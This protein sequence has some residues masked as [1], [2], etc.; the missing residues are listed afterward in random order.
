M[1][2]CVIT[3]FSVLQPF[4]CEQRV[5]KSIESL[6]SVRL[7]ADQ[8]ARREDHLSGESAVW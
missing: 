8:P 1:H 5:S 6:S 4:A 2:M 3:F 7:P